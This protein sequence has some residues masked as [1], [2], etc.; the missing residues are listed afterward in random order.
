MKIVIVGG[1]AAGAK[2]AAKSR[3]LLPDAEIDIYT[4]DTHVSYSACGLPY[5]I[6]GNFEDYK[7][8]LVRT[9]EEF[10]L[11]GI[12]VHLRHKITKIIPKTKQILVENLE[13]PEC[14]LV[15]YDKLILATGAR[16]FIPNIKHVALNNVFTLRT[17]EDGIAIRE[18]VESSKNA[19]IIGGGYIGIELLEACVKQGLY[20][21]L[22]ERN[23]TIMPMFDSDISELIKNQLMSINDG[24]FEI[25]TSDSVTEMVGD[26][27]GVTSVKTASGKEIE[28]NLVILCAGVVPNVEVAIDAG[29]SLGETGAIKVTPKMETNISDIYA[30][31]DCVEEIHLISNTPVWVPLGSNANKEGRCAAMNACGFEDEFPGVL[32]SAV[33][34]CMKLTMSMTGLTETQAKKLGYETVSATVTKYDKVGYMPDANN[35]TLKLVADKKTK[36]LIGGQ[37]IGAGDADKRIN[38]LATALIAKL[39]VDEFYN[40]D[41]TYSPPFSPTIDPLLNAAQILISKLESGS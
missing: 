34:R 14:F 33:T 24:K 13:T 12:N 26:N 11:S 36:R 16:P 18:K 2:A 32:A 8:L 31:G 25:I 40:N 39:T 37:G 23:P 28:T 9:P 10:A 30:C 7:T 41:L 5:Y 20:T 17:I 1:V 19:V 4:Q 21:T 6:E 27:S 15:R 38:T 3:R 22:I 35:I 29:I